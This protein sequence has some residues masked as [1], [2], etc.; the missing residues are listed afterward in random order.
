[1][2][3]AAA[4]NRVRTLRFLLRHGAQAD[5]PGPLGNTPLHAAAH[6]GHMA[7]VAFLL[8]AGADPRARNAVG[9]SPADFARKANVR[10]V[11][12]GWGRGRPLL[13]IAMSAAR[14]SFAEDPTARYR[15][16]ERLPRPLAVRV[17]TP[18][19]WDDGDVEPA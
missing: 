4:Q 3:I 9:Q 5:L 16:L 2:H 10:S 13:D 18:V 1:M 7:A 6:R 15:L 11:I 8:A 17:L 19:H 14:Q 12:E